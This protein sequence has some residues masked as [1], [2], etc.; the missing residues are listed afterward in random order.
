MRYWLARL[1]GHYY[2]WFE[3]FAG[4]L[5]LIDDFVGY[6]FLISKLRNE[7]ITT[8]YGDFL[9]IGSFLGGGTKKLAKLAVE[10][11]RQVHVIDVFNPNYD[12]TINSDSISMAWIYSKI[13]GSRN[14]FEEFSKRIKGF[15]NIIVHRGDSRIVD[16]R[17]ARFVFSFIDGGHSEEVVM[18]DFETVWAR[19]VS[20]GVVAFHDYGG[21]LPV[22]TNSLDVMLDKYNCEIKQQRI[23][24]QQK[25]LWIQKQ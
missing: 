2:V 13:L 23:Y 8:K 18:H 9:E 19:T 10:Q 11:E 15:Q 6:D 17:D 16:L 7:G 14:L 22:V 25:I 5:G 3:I 20:G 21:D 4:R 1:L 12:S 24:T